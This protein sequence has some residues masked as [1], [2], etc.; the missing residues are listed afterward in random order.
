MANVTAPQFQIDVNKFAEVTNGNENTVVTMRLGQK[1][2]TVAKVINDIKTKADEINAIASMPIIFTGQTSNVFSLPYQIDFAQIQVD[3]ELLPPS[4]DYYII[5]NDA[6]TLTVFADINEGTIVTVRAAMLS[7]AS[8]GSIASGLKTPMDY[9]A[10]GNGVADDTQAVKDWLAGENL[11]YLGDNDYY[12]T[13]TLSVND[14][15]GV[16]WYPSKGRILSEAYNQ[17]VIEFIDCPNCDINGLN[18]DMSMIDTENQNVGFQNGLLISKCAN[19]KLR[20][21]NI[22]GAPSQAVNV[23]DK[24]TGFEILNNYIY[25]AGRLQQ[26]NAGTGISIGGGILIFNSADVLTHGNILNRTW[27]AGIFAYAATTE[28]GLPVDFEAIKGH[29]ITNNIIF[30]SQSN[31]IRLQPDDYPAAEL[32]HDNLIDGNIVFNTGRTCIRPNGLRITTTNNIVG[33]N[34]TPIY[35][36]LTDI[37]NNG[38]S[39][40]HCKD[41]RIS[42][43]TIIGCAA[44]FEPAPNG[45]ANYGIE[46]TSFTE[47]TIINCVYGIYRSG[48]LAAPVDGL[49]I[50]DNTFIHGGKVVIDGGNEFD[51]REILSM[52]NCTNLYITDNKM[53]GR[54][55]V[56]D[57]SASI[58]VTDSDSV[59][60]TD[61]K[62]FG[63]S[64]SNS[65]I[66]CTDI[67]AEDNKFI[68]CY[69]SGAAF[70]NCD[71]VS[72]TGNTITFNESDSV[73][74]VGIAFD[75]V[76]YINAK[77]NK[78]K[79]LSVNETT[80]A[81]LIANTTDS[82]ASL[83][84][85]SGNTFDTTNNINNQINEADGESLAQFNNYNTRTKTFDNIKCQTVK[86]ETVSINLTGSY[87]GSVVSYSD[88]TT[89]NINVT[90]G[91]PVGYSFSAVNTIG[92]LNVNLSSE[93]FADG[94]DTAEIKSG[95]FVK[96]ADSSWMKIIE[97]ASGAAAPNSIGASYGF[98][99]LLAVPVN[100]TY[101]TIY[102]DTSADY[103]DGGFT[104]VG[105]KLGVPNGIGR[106][107]LF[108]TIT[109]PSNSVDA[110]GYYQI[111]ISKYNSSNA[112]LGIVATS[113]KKVT[114]VAATDVAVSLTVLGVEV[115]DGDYFI[116]RGRGTPFDTSPADYTDVRI[117][118]KKS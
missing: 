28:S 45:L 27:S 64:S 37:P 91:L 3:G 82:D 42:N 29:R 7:A 38:I 17:T 95:H 46:N 99:A 109:Y 104:M 35:G 9:N 51:D 39:S 100:E 65:I 47:N 59:Y 36:S 114:G 61:N 63:S 31:G 71:D 32:S 105:G 113:G 112:F 77:D 44:G 106:V 11:Y 108:T 23:R 89:R 40:N 92:D 19:G 20:N 85:I 73:N 33:F 103:N 57:F 93:T 62:T 43:N 67:V 80:S 70:V 90:S 84:V 111:E 97:G 54:S 48:D 56:Y 26:I 15:E 41:S 98:N 13:E 34:G 81:M 49:D 5:D 83:G 72:A 52:S 75:N 107:D 6:Q 79:S 66:D 55:S 88:A 117:T 76:E 102:Y 21:S 69:Y 1:V 94:T 96:V 25:E 110:G 30:E 4:D 14:K 2:D 24:S 58:T 115:S 22:I 16:V 12:V 18:L 78:I 60:V 8:A 116:V 86:P 87:N 118:A 50:T 10:A 68:D 101:S 74:T 53:Y